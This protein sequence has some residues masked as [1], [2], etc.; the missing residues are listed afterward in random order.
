MYYFE[1]AT[2]EELVDLLVRPYRSSTFSFRRLEKN[3]T[4]RLQF[5]TL[6]FRLAIRCCSFRFAILLKETLNAEWFLRPGIFSYNNFITFAGIT[7]KIVLFSIRPSLGKT[8]T[9]WTTSLYLTQLGHFY[10]RLQGH[11]F[12]A[13]YL[14]PKSSLL[15]ICIIIYYI[16]YHNNILYIL[17]WNRK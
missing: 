14:Q 16:I 3:L 13:H 17:I 2:D 8:L 15:I 7:Y 10:S 4:F 5:I 11:C 1:R 9:Y 6:W 12:P